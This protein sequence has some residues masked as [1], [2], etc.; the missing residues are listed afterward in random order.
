MGRC[1]ARAGAA[2]ASTAAFRDRRRLEVR[3][4]GV[5]VLDRFPHASTQA[6]G[7]RDRIAG[8]EYDLLAITGWISYQHCATPRH[9]RRAQRR[10]ELGSRQPARAPHVFWSAV[11]YL[12]PA[13]GDHKVIWELNRHQHW[14]ALGRAFWL[15][16]DA[17]YRDAFVAE[18]ASWLDANPPLTGINWA[19][20]LELALPIAVVD[21]GA[22]LLR[23]AP[24]RT[25]SPWMVDLL[26]ALDR[27]LTHIERNLSHYFS[28]NTHLLGEALALY[29]AGRA[30]PE[31]RGQRARAR[32]SAAR[33]LLA[34]DRPADRSRRR[35]L[36]A[37]D[38]LPPLHAR[39]LPARADRR[40]AHRRSGRGARS[41]TRSRARRA[42]RACSPT[43]TAASRT[44]ATT[45][46]GRC[47]RLP[48]GPDDIAR[49]PGDRGGARRPPRASHRRSRR[50]KR[51]AARASDRQPARQPAARRSAPVRR[52]R[53]GGAAR[54]RLL[55]LALAGAAITSSST[56]DR[57]AIRTAATRTPTRCR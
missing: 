45:T 47:C 50:K 30:L 43:T 21:V 41:R 17:R 9:K 26:V 48:A 1:A 13:C 53:V 19:S 15:T 51:L 33:I 54:H 29:V 7:S 46:A 18:L 10:L 25:T 14:L 32:R 52:P 2:F 8:G 38:A 56:A 42:P 34:G 39:L 20:M 31:L 57:T 49:Q 27:Q 35:P 22:P 28:P 44:S 4:H 16:G 11:P 6:A 40:A 55:R 24:T 5:S 36:R 3:P 37:L 12:D 23:R